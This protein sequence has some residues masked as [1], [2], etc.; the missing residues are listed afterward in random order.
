[1]LT[2]SLQRGKT[3]PL[4]KCP[5]YNTK[6]SDY[7]AQSLENVENHFI[8]IMAMKWVFDPEW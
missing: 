3:L 7:E 6:Q 8:S 2:R 1:M 5:E 4:N